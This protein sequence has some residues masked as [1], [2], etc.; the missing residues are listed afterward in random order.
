MATPSPE[1]LQ[2]VGELLTDSTLRILVQATYKLGHAPEALSALTGK[3]THGKL[4]IQVP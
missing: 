2:R 3:H 1:N 4:A